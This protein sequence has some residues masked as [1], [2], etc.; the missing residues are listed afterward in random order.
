MNLGLGLAA[1]GVFG[2][3]FVYYWRLWGEPPDDLRHPD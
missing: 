2:L 1:L 3:V